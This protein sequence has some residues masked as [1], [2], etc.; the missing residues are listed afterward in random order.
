MTDYRDVLVIGGGI[1]GLLCAHELT[2]RGSSVVVLDAKLDRP[3]ASWA[4][5]GILASLYPWRSSAKILALTE[6]AFDSYQE[7]LSSL[8]SARSGAVE[9]WQPGVLFRDLADQDQALAWAS[10]HGVDLQQRSDHVLFLPGTGVINNSQLLQALR[11]DLLARNRLVLT[12]VEH[13]SHNHNNWC[14][15][16]DQGRWCG[17]QLVL[18]AGVWSASILDTIDAGLSLSVCRGLKPVK[19]QMLRYAPVSGADTLNHIVLSDAGYLVPRRDGSILVGSTMEPDILDQRPTHAAWVSLRQLAARLLPA[20]QDQQPVAQW[21]GLRPGSPEGVPWIGPVAGY[22][23]LFIAT[24]H[25]RNGIACAPATARK[26]AE[27]LTC[28]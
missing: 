15:V 10:S 4:A 1:T 7:I 12:R 28:S 25:H 11:Q 2:H 19:G 20:L 3:C 22:D 5:G 17:K 14:L 9:L 6:G 13:I 24:G 18:A 26:M 16:T 21:A 27:L 23:D 8:K